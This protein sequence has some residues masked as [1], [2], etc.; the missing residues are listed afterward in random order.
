MKQGVLVPNYI[1]QFGRQFKYIKSIAEILFSDFLLLVKT[2]Q[3]EESHMLNNILAYQLYQIWDKQFCAKLDH[4]FETRTYIWLE[5]YAISS[6]RDLVNNHLIN[7]C[8]IHI[9]IFSE[10]FFQHIQ[11]TI[12]FV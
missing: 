6:D 11:F 12:R 3:M 8:N 5:N 9:D 10:I 7:F 2:L 1:K 4:T